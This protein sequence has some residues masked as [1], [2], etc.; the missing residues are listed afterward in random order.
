MRFIEGPDLATLIH[1]GGPLG[2]YRTCAILGQIADA[3]DVAHG[4]GLV[5]LDVKPGNILLAS[6]PTGHPTTPFCP[7]SA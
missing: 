1:N 5:H 7:T 4:A 6:S 2:P 3:L